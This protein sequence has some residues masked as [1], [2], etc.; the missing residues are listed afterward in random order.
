MEEEAVAVTEQYRMEKEKVSGYQQYLDEIQHQ[1]DTLSSIS[2][3]ADSQ[4][5]SF[6]SRNIEK[7]A[8]D[9]EGLDSKNVRW[10]PSKG[11]T[12]SMDNLWSDLLLLLSVF[13]FVGFT[14]GEEK[15]RSLFAITRA[16]R[17][18]QF[19]SMA[20]KFAALLIHC[21]LATVLLY[22]CNLLYFSWTV[23]LGDLTA[24]IQSVV[25]YMESPLNMTLLTY[26]LLA[27]LTKALVCFAVGAL[28]TALT[29]YS[30]SGY[31]PYLGGVV[32]VAVGWLCY[33]I[34]P[35][36]SLWNPL[37]YLNPYALLQTE[38]L[39]GGYLN[40]NILGYPFS[41]LWLSWIVLLVM[42]FL[43]IG[44]SLALFV[45]SGTH[46]LQAQPN[47]WRFGWKGFG[48]KPHGNLFLHEAYKVLIADRVLVALLI[49]TLLI[50]GN[51]LSQNYHPS[52]Q[53]QYYQDLM[54]KLEG[55]LTD[56]KKDLIEAE[57]ARYE[58]A[59]D[60]IDRIDSMVESGKLSESAG[61]SMKLSWYSITA[62]YPTFERVLTQY[63]KI[64]AQGGTFVYDTGYLYLFGISDDSLPLYLL[65]L[66]LAV[67]FSAANVLPMEDERQTWILIGAT[68]AGRWQIIKRKVI[69][70][71][72]FAAGL[73]LLPWLCRGYAI[74]K[75]FPLHEMTAAVQSIPQFTDFLLTMPIWGFMVLGILSQTLA[76]L[77]LAAIVLCLS[78]WR[79]HHLQTLFFSLLLL[80]VPLMLKLLGL[81]FAGWFSLWP[82]YGWMGIVY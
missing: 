21:L 9:Y 30:F 73:S 59:F 45:G 56:E 55:E 17:Y 80:A 50:G 2:I 26:L 74:G 8:A 62:F 40:F 57:S 70:V 16:T 10:V 75:A 3:F 5:A 31:A 69:L 72:I 71:I 12:Q 22:G 79:K 53:E 34:I 67:I 39:Y 65:F 18:G 13:L 1:K 43:G 20:S 63:Q 68:K 28:L 78:H 35:A 47:P 54:M 24:R 23:G 60:Q 51:A 81:D 42:M 29:L 27:T 33:R 66:T 64:T 15:V 77:L 76:I 41:R 19:H 11:I 82:L 32:M 4:S 52:V 46:C 58:E 48:F 38:N 25:A 14:I 61:D 7:S 37:K 36:S 6:S 44:L 49:F